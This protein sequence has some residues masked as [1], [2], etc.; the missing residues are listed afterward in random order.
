MRTTE[1][2]KI[3][4]AIQSIADQRNLVLN[5]A[6]ESSRAGCTKG[7]LVVAEEIKK[8]SDRTIETVC[9]ELK[10]VTE[11]M[12]SLNNRMGEIESFGRTLRSQMEKMREPMSSTLLKRLVGVALRR[13]EKVLGTIRHIFG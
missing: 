2:G 7:F 12:D 1:T 8:L 6:I 5:T 9:Q 11:S 13:Q 4:G 3:A 10:R